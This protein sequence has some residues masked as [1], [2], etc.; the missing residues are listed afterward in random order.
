VGLPIAWVPPDILL[1]SDEKS[2]AQRQRYEEIIQNLHRN[3]D[4]GI[5]MP[6]VFDK[7]GNK[8]FNIS[9]LGPG[10]QRTFSTSEIIDR[11]DKRIAMTVLADFLFLGQGSTGTYALAETR[12]DLF[13]MSITS[14]LDAIQEVINSYAIPKLFRL[15]VFDNPYSLPQ[16]QHGKV[17]SINLSDLGTFVS[18]LARAGIAI[19][20][21]EQINYLLRMANMPENPKDE[22]MVGTPRSDTS[23]GPEART[24]GTERTTSGG[25]NAE[26]PTAK[27]IENIPGGGYS[28]MESRRS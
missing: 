21:V 25:P 22:S 15:N 23:S 4:E 3:E 6:S 12:N 1:G 24:A 7:S 11:Y 14:I 9:L 18:M 2:V 13:A 20:D 17:S 28:G 5:L 26:V 10:G 19:T 27:P 8:M 16:L